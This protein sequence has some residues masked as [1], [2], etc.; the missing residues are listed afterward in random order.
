[1]TSLVTQIGLSVFAGEVDAAVTPLAMRCTEITGSVNS[2][3]TLRL[4]ADELNRRLCDI[5][6]PAILQ[7]LLDQGGDRK[8][9]WTRHDIQDTALSLRNEFP[10][11]IRCGAAICVQSREF[12]A[13]L[14]DRLT[15]EAI[16]LKQMFGVDAS[17]LTG[18]RTL[19]DY[20]ERQFAVT[21]LTF[22]DKSIIY[23]PRPLT[24]EI[25]FYAVWKA[26]AN[27]AKVECPNPIV[28]TKNTHGWMAALSPAPCPTLG[29]V[30]TYCW[31]LGFAAS[32]LEMLRSGDHHAE[33]II[34]RSTWP[35]FVDLECTL[36]PSLSIDLRPQSRFSLH[37]VGIEDVTEAPFTA[38]PANQA[39]A[40]DNFH[41][42]EVRWSISTAR[43]VEARLIAR[44]PK[45]AAADPRPFSCL[46]P[47]KSFAKY[48]ARGYQTGLTAIDALH[49][50]LTSDNSPIRTL[51]VTKMRVVLR[52][53]HFYTQLLRASFAPTLAANTV[54]RLDFL[55][56]R[57][58][59]AS[60]WLNCASIA[61]A[62]ALQ[63]ATIP[64][65]HHQPNSRI[66]WSDHR[67]IHNV[68]TSSG[69]E[70][71]LRDANER[72]LR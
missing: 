65:F 51:G 15:D 34:A 55:R 57:L 17:A 26:V 35:Y 50:D 9:N 8:R 18:L 72:R 6:R 30:T 70:S 14:L 71:F 7:C 3:R 1:M 13:D 38:L 2:G 19:G 22:G 25:V 27:H 47:L 12:V 36:I 69:I 32:V 56:S 39:V 53:T 42:S 58:P 31:N 59:P 54:A 29:K 67:G 23:K 4:F 28:L 44:S 5:G 40:M 46:I 62:R 64:T 68:I 24:A 10:E 48:F 49:H 63:D 61:E 37:A 21:E 45:K 60:A 11:L 41:K 43:K 33:N 52:S 66:L 20:H 16:Q